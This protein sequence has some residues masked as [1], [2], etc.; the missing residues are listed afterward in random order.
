M[1]KSWFITGTL[2]GFGRIM[3]EQLLE[4]GDRVVAT[5]LKP[6]ALDALKAKYGDAVLVEE[7]DVTDNRAIRRVVDSAFERLGRI[8]VIVSNAGYGLFGAAEE[9]ADD[10][11]RHQIETNL[12]GSIQLTRAVLPHLR[13]QGGGRILQL[14]SMGGQIAF[15]GLSLYHTTKWAIEGFFE[16]LVK[17]VAPFNI[18]V[19]LIEPGSARTNFGFGSLVSASP[20]D[21]YADTPVGE[22]RKAVAAYDYSLKG[23]PAKMVREMIACVDISPAP[24]RL[25]LGKDAYGLVHA[26]LSQ[27]LAKLEAQKNIAF[28]TDFDA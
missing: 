22:W 2:S 1:P 18:E 11:I 19:T 9:L 7:L 23:D 17:E 14:S 3:T 4:R 26:A 6:E 15:P 5:L 13:R 10:Q 25:T 27:R 24:L 20:L 28:S 21:A 12:L 8:D 16:A